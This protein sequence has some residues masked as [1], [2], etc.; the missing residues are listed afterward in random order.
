MNTP[1][2]DNRAHDNGTHDSRT[3]DPRRD[4][5]WQ[6]QERALRE[7]RAGLPVAA[8]DARV[9][10]YRLISRALRHPPL[11]AVP[12]DFARDL[13]RRVA[14]GE[15][16][17][18]IERWLLRSLVGLMGLAGAVVVAMYGAAW[19]PAIAQLLPLPAG[20]LARWSL[21]LAACAGT[22]WMLGQVLR[23]EAPTPA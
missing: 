19:W 1:T 16:D 6:A 9:A 8:G 5:E 7:E 22:T 2:H 3:T 15:G 14:R 20:E 13:A 4:A 12:Y 17:E 23:S 10:E 18:R 21:V 11:D